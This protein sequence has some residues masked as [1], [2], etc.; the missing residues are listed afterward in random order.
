MKGQIMKNVLSE[1]IYYWKHGTV[2]DRVQIAIRAVSLVA[3]LGIVLV[4]LPVT[5]HKSEAATSFKLGLAV[6]V[7]ATA[8]AGFWAYSKMEDNR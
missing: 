8:A 2:S 5:I 1:H 4:L 3:I 6:L 7:V